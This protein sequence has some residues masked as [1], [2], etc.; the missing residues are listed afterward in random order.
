[1]F[2]GLIS[3]ARLTVDEDEQVLPSDTVADELVDERSFLR[4]A[5]VE[6][7]SDDEFSNS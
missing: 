3:K 7:G 1:M 2:P 4:L 5:G 6:L